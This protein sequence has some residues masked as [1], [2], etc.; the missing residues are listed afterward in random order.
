MFRISFRFDLLSLLE[1]FWAGPK[2]NMGR[3]LYGIIN[4]SFQFLN[5]LKIK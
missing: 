4:S 3:I 2:S 5:I 1:Q